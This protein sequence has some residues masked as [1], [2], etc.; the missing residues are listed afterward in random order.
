MGTGVFVQIMAHIE[1]QAFLSQYRMG[2][3][4]QAGFNETLCNSTKIAAFR[5]PSDKM[6]NFW[7]PSNY[8]P[9]VGPNLC[10]G[11]SKNWGVLNESSR[12]GAFRFYEET[13]FSDITDG[14]SNT[15][16]LGEKLVPPYDGSKWIPGN[17]A[18]GANPPTGM[19]YSTTLGPI[20][21]QMVDAY[22]T[23]AVAAANY[24]GGCRTSNYISSLL[25]VNE[26]APPNWK[27]PD[28][29][30]L[31]GCPAPCGWGINTARSK[32]P[33]GVNMAMADAS[34]RFISET[35]DLVTWQGLGSRNGRESITVP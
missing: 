9:S 33:G 20:T 19:P 35:I 2:C 3:G 21:Q 28:V 25:S 24:H 7:S 32:H 31:G 1:Q 5:C 8:A 29:T 34:V 18:R 16:L 12:N 14:S 26:V 27:F 13:S 10:I 30:N 17:W 23:A 15:F 4:W 22:G 11:A 6:E